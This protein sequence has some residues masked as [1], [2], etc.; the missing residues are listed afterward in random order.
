MHLIIARAYLITASFGVSSL[1]IKPSNFYAKYVY[2]STVPRE[3]ILQMS[4]Q[5]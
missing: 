5:I 1:E 2:K 4:E 3:K